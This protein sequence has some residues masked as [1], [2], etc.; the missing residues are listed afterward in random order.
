MNTIYRGSMNR[1][2][3]NV[4]EQTENIQ[5]LTDHTGFVKKSMKVREKHVRRTNLKI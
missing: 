2:G 5:E 1:I 4:W 3:K